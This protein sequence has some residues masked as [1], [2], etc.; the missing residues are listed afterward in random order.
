MESGVEAKVIT[1]TAVNALRVFWF[2]L[3]ALCGMV[4]IMALWLVFR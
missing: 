3:G 4:F 2:W 1:A